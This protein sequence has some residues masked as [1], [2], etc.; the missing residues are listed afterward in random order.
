MQY[1]MSPYG[2]PPQF[3]HPTTSDDPSTPHG[4]SSQVHSSCFD[5]SYVI[6]SNRKTVTG[7]SHID[8]D[9]I[10][11][12]YRRRATSYMATAVGTGI[13]RAINAVG[14]SSRCWILAATTST[15]DTSLAP[16]SGTMDAANAAG[17]SSRRPADAMGNIVDAMRTSN[18]RVRSGMICIFCNYR[19]RIKNSIS[20]KSSQI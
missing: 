18:R 1:V 15:L 2:P 5:C 7:I 10:W 3:P 20:C 6:N 12:I 13:G 8:D 19:L 11:R 14:T 9:A 4:D 16:W 17:T